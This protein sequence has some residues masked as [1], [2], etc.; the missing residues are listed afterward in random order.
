MDKADRLRGLVFGCALGDAVGLATEF[1]TAKEASAAYAALLQERAATNSQQVASLR[2]GDAV[3]DGHRSKWVAGDWTD[4]TDQLILVLQSMISSFPID[5]PPPIAPPTSTHPPLADGGADDS[6]IN[7]R[8]DTTMGDLPS[9]DRQSQ[10]PFLHAPNPSAFASRLLSWHRHGFPDLGDNSGCGMGRATA[11]VVDDPKFVDQPLVVARRVWDETARC[12]AP[13]GALMRAAATGIRGR[14][15]AAADAATIA[16]TT[17]ADPRSTAACVAVATTIASM[18]DGCKAWRSPSGGLRF[19]ILAKE[20]LEA[21][22]A[23]LPEESELG[24]AP[25][26]VWGCPSCT[27]ENPP[28]AAECQVCYGPAPAPG[29]STVNAGFGVTWTESEASTRSYTR[30]AAVAELRAAV[31]GSG[32]PLKVDCPHTMG[33]VNTCLAAAFGALRRACETSLGGD[34]FRNAVQEL[35]MAGGDA[36][37]NAAVAGALLGCVVG[38]QQLPAGWLQALPHRA[39]LERIADALV[40]AATGCDNVAS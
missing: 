3:R 15:H 30:G 22:E 1:M 37:T 5:L 26:P 25:K 38:A 7:P 8:T 39:W 24:P 29:M 31:L 9:S 23:Y 18:L 34:A 14:D 11:R 19:E 35:T 17:H 10:L 36:D 27:F 40:E 12:F 32:E 16:Q 4:D 28:D 21:A 13:N 2:P 33:Y 20:A 6:T